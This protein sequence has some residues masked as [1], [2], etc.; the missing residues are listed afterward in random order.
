MREG[1]Q[2]VELTESGEHVVLQEG[3]NGVTCRVPMEGDFFIIRCN[4]ISDQALFDRLDS[5]VVRG[6]KGWFD[7]R[8]I[9]F[10]EIDDGKLKPPTMGS[11]H[12]FIA[13]EDFDS[14]GM[15]SLIFL[16]GVMAGDIGMGV[17]ADNE[18]PWMMW[19]GTHLAHVMIHGEWR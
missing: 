4:P 16:P 15:E 11:T 19:E 9:V 1:T 5:M 13:G 8:D 10:E 2:V 12:Y 3:D 18:R 7:A 17:E 6:G 14:A